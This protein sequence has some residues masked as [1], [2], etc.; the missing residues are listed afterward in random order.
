M[1]EQIDIDIKTMRAKARNVVP[2]LKMVSNENRLLILCHLGMGE[3]SV[4][5]LNERFDLSQSALS[6]ASCQ[7]TAGWAGKNPA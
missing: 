4:T 1:L 7:V 6:P 2:L 5:A 3:M